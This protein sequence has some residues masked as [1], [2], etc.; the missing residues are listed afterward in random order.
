MSWSVQAVGKPAAVATKVQADLSVFRCTEP[1]ETVKQAACTALV[2]AINAQAPNTVIKVS[3]SGSQSNLYGPDGKVA[4]VQNNLQMSVE[5]I[6]G[7][8]E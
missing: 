4:G 5:P 2:A 8:V 3:A 1:E 7:F 6:Y